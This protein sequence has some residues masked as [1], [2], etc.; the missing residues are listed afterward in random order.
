M[1]KYI[2]IVLIRI[3]PLRCGGE[4]ICSGAHG[5][6]G[7]ISRWGSGSGIMTNDECNA[8][9]M[10]S[11]IEWQSESSMPTRFTTW[12]DGAGKLANKFWPPSVTKISTPMRSQWRCMK[13]LMVNGWRAYQRNV[14]S[15]RVS[16]VTIPSRPMS[17]LSRHG[18]AISFSMWCF[19]RK[20]Y[21]VR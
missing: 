6:G 7:C 5:T 12:I 17:K 2:N 18:K 4:P 3:S 11:G 8:L 9:R 10:F 1:Q 21:I 15:L 16:L 13:H 20:C 14:P 19:I